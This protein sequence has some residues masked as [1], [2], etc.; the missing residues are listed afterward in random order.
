M[1]RLDLET[2]EMYLKRETVEI[3]RWDAIDYNTVYFLFSKEPLKSAVNSLLTY[4]GIP[5][6][7]CHG[8]EKISDECGSRYKYSKELKKVGRFLYPAGNFDDVL[9]FLQSAARRNAPKNAAKYYYDFV[10]PSITAS[11][12]RNNCYHEPSWIL[13]KRFWIDVFGVLKCWSQLDKNAV[14]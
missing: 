7:K 11:L 5:L 6:K 1:D 2:F 10:I 4:F 14:K 12:E 13:W 9:L 8:V 3:I